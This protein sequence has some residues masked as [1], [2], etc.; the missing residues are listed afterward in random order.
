MLQLELSIFEAFMVTTIVVGGGY[1]LYKLGVFRDLKPHLSLEHSV[2]HRPVG[3]DY[4]HIA[5]QVSLLN[6]SKVAVS[7]TEAICVVQQIAPLS[8]REIETLYDETFVSN[9]EIDI[10]WPLLN[11]YQKTRPVNELI[12]EPQGRHVDYYETHIS[13]DI[14]T[15]LVSTRYNNAKFSDGDD[16][17]RGWE[18]SSAHDVD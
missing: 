6:T 15:N 16:A 1:A 4:I 11:Q 14:A 8:N 9:N 10:Q 7:I 5:M 12:I 3:D 17:A 2:T 18:L 13:K